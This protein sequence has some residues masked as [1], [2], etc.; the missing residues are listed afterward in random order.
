MLPCKNCL[1]L[2]CCISKYNEYKEESNRRYTAASRLT[3]SCSILS[4]Y[5]FDADDFDV[6]DIR[7]DYII[8]HFNRTYIR[9]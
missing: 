9:S 4:K 2:A 5:I 6:F 3:Y 7:L 8:N 1:V